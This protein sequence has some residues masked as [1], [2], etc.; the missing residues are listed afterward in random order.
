M[1]SLAG[2]LAPTLSTIREYNAGGE[3]VR[4]TVTSESILKTVTESTRNKLVFIN[5]QSWVAGLRAVPPG[6]SI[7]NPAGVFE[8][9]AGKCDVTM[10]TLP[11]SASNMT[12]SNARGLS[13][14]IEAARSGELSIGS[15]GLSAT[16]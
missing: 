4:E 9:L 1:L 7:E 14:I 10:L 11:A 15:S 5:N 12:P 13:Q 3:L 16:E 2:C 8:L 6:S